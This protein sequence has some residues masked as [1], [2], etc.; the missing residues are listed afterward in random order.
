VVWDIAAIAS[1]PLAM[2]SPSGRLVSGWA[3]LRC[4]RCNQRCNVAPLPWIPQAKCALQV[5]V[6][7]VITRAYGSN[8]AR[9]AR[10]HSSSNR[11]TPA[12]DAYHD[13]IAIC[14]QRVGWMVRQ[15]SRTTSIPL[16]LR[17]R[18]AP[19]CREASAAG[20]TLQHVAG[21]AES[22]LHPCRGSS[23]K[24]LQD[25][26]QRTGS[27]SRCPPGALPAGPGAC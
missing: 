3:A 24:V 11:R 26:S 6:V 14:E 9:I 8:G 1:E 22:S 19:R 23:L 17:C 7:L 2:V 10:W 13:P 16:C 18:L 27:V 5:F 12:D 20:R 21:R 4:L 25:P 15:H